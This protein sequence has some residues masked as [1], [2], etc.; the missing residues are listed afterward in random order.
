MFGDST[1]RARP[2]PVI[3]AVAFAFYLSFVDTGWQ[4]VTVNTFR[5]NGDKASVDY[6]LFCTSPLR[7]D[8][9]GGDYG[10]S[11]LLKTQPVS[12]GDVVYHW[13][14]GDGMVFEKNKPADKVQIA[15]FLSGKAGFLWV[16]DNSGKSNSPKTQF[17]FSFRDTMRADDRL[18]QQ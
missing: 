4:K 2:S 3:P 6:L 11:V 18:H 15:S 14:F 12:D 10:D 9:I 1:V 5:K 8:S 7:Q 16:S 13:D 17:S